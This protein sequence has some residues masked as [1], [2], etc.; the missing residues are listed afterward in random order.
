[1]TL[2]VRY[3]VARKEDLSSFNRYEESS[4]RDFVRLVRSRAIGE[5]VLIRLVRGIKQPGFRPSGTM[6][7]ERSASP[8]SSGTRNQ[9]GVT[10][11]VRYEVAR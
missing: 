5:L 7:C 4:R 2:S 8:S 1:M 3:E 11:S 9:A 10:S 6:S